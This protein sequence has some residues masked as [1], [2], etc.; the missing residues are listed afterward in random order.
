M[1]GRSSGGIKAVQMER[2]IR[3]LGGSV[4]AS[5]GAYRSPAAGC[6]LMPAGLLAGG[7]VG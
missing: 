5:S 4:A 7:A 6:N 2:G 3:A 1:T